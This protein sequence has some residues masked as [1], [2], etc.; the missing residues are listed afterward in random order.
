MCFENLPIEFDEH[1]NASLKEGVRNPY[2]YQ[3]R[4]VEERDA[5]LK[6]IAIKNGQMAN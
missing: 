2:E 5:K 6:E 4:T 3:T 1:G